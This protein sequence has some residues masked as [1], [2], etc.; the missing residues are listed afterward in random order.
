MLKYVFQYCFLPQLLNRNHEIF[1]YF[2]YYVF[3]ATIRIDEVHIHEKDC[4]MPYWNVSKTFSLKEGPFQ[5]FRIKITLNRRCDLQKRNCSCSVLR[6]AAQNYIMLTFL[7][8]AIT[9]RMLTL[10]N[11]EL[12][13]QGV[14]VLLWLSSRK[15]VQ[16]Y[17]NYLQVIHIFI[18]ITQTQFK[19]LS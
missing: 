2:T 13:F 1:P 19:A 12:K 6:Q 9:W 7:C 8:S 10:P 18:F 4:S 11:R 3:V 15:V 17:N 5:Y 14:I 16:K